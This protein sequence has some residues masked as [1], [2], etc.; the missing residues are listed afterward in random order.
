MGV[1]G[2]ERAGVAW[3]GVVAAV[4]GA[5][6]LAGLLVFAVL[7]LSVVVVDGWAV[8]WHWH[9]WLLAVANAV[10]MA[11]SEG[12]RGFG[13]GFSPRCAARVMWLRDNPT[14]RL[15]VFA[16]FFVMGYFRATRR[17]LIG[18]WALTAAIVVAIVVVHALPQPW[19]AVLD[20]G[21]VVGLCWGLATFGAA[22]WRAARAPNYPV[23]PEVQ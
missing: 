8:P 20:I 5:A 23:S 4:W 3:L 13:Q 11:W 22:L 17:R 16:P 19:R 10:F 14:A 1:D 7:R 9:H 6:G 18:T 21:V 12:H 2:R 15:A